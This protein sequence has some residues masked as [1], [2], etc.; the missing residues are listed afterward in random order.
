MKQMLQNLKSGKIAVA[1]VPR[2]LLLPEGILVRTHKSLISAGTERMMLQLGKKSLLGKA[3]ALT[4]TEDEA[5][6]L[7]SRL[8]KLELELTG[9]ERAELDEVAG[10]PVR[11]IVRGLVDAVDADVQAQATA[12]AADPE[13]A[14][15]ELIERAVEPLAANPELRERILE[16]RATHDR[17]I[18]EVNPDVLLDAHGVVDPSRAKDVIE[19]WSEY[20]TK[21][22][23]E[24]TAIQ[25]ATEAKDRR[26]R[27]ADIQE[28]ADRIS[29]PP[30]NWTAD[31]IWD[32]YAQ[33]D[34][35]R[36]R[37]SDRHTL[38]DLVSLLRFTLGVD[39]ELVPYADVVRE[40]YAGWLAQQEQAGT[41][42]TERE[43]WWLDRM[44]DV[45]AA[46][47]G[48]SADDLDMSPFDERGGVDGILR[49]LGDRAESLI[50]ELNDELTA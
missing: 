16:L 46:S 12:G 20:L 3:A 36:V 49:D 41:V 37:K 17:I 39:D 4:L 50:A 35:D 15:R 23:S 26:F 22:R 13:E 25:V 42:F 8:A 47:A 31:I 10:R 1:D 43:R 27:F 44:V 19:S 40:R 30:H 33:V 9:D 11:E 45:I 38:T 21:H 14:V 6:T 5:A 2:P 34:A 29:R 32:A 7:A 48:I 18:D 24:I 28:L